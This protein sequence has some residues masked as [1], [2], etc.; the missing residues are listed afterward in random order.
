MRIY[1]LIFSFNL[2]CYTGRGQTN[3]CQSRD[4]ATTFSSQYC[5]AEGVILPNQSW[6]QCKLYCLQTASCEAVNYNVTGNLCATL[7]AT[8]PK[9]NSHPGMVFAL[10]TGRK[11]EQCLEWIPTQDRNPVGDR[12]VTEENTRFVA[13]MQ[14]D[15]NDFVGYMG[16]INYVCLSSDDKGKIK[17]SNGFPCQYLR[18]SSGCTVMFMDYEIGAPLPHMALIGGYTADRRPVYIGLWLG[19]YPGYYIPG[20]KKLFA[21]FTSQTTNVKVLV[22]LWIKPA[23]TRIW[24]RSLH[25]IHRCGCG[26]PWFIVCSYI[27]LGTISIL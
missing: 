2:L 18:I 1:T 24:L 12:S 3:K 9:A 15:G 27:H 22:L 20:S 4:F 10:F 13:R 21:G 11:P 5:P 26:A 17:S 6:R 25:K 16:I 19:I 23:C 14:K 8:C 7:P